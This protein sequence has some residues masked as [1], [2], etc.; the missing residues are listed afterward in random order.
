M[1]WAAALVWW[2]LSG[3]IVV[4]AFPSLRRAYME[5]RASGGLGSLPPAK[6]ITRLL[7]VFP[8]AALFC[9][10]G[11]GALV[12]AL[13]WFQTGEWP[14]WSPAALGYEAPETAYLGLNKIL[15]WFYDRPLPLLAVVVGGIMLLIASQ[16]DRI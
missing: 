3:A 14:Q 15:R 8:A 11:V 6:L 1:N 4:V 7:L 2:G 16:E 13:D 12:M 5:S 10:A 9:A